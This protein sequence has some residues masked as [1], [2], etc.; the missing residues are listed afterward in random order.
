MGHE[1]CQ[2]LHLNPASVVNVRAVP[3][4]CRQRPVAALSSKRGASFHRPA[5]VDYPSGWRCHV[6]LPRSRAPDMKGTIAN[7]IALLNI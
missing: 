1:Y 6:V 2:S 5:G 4:F 3:P 7:S